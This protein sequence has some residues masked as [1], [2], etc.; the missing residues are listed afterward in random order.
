[1]DRML[2]I[3]S[4]NDPFKKMKALLGES[5]SVVFVEGRKKAIEIINNSSP[6]D[7]VITNLSLPATDGINT[8]FELKE[9]RKSGE[10]GPDEPI[11]YEEAGI[12][13]LKLAKLKSPLTEVIITTSFGQVGDIEKAKELD[14]FTY[15][16]ITQQNWEHILK[17]II[18][19]ALERRTL[20][21]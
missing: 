3:V 20:R 18:E 2:M 8:S 12:E 21:H 1:M 9:K 11:T 6:F 14:V 13:I 17:M 4:W 5:G 16:D 7:L 19:R 15:V 10:I